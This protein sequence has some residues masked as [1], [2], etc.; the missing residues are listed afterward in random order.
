MMPC[1]NITV[2][3][4]SPG[5]FTC[6]RCANEYGYDGRGFAWPYYEDFIIGD[7]EPWQERGGFVSVCRCCY[8]EL[9]AAEAVAA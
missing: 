8:L 5:W 2:V 7:G 3:C 6:H 9:L 4:L 1:A